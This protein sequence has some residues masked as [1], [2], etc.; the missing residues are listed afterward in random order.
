MRIFEKAEYKPFSGTDYDM[1]HNGILKKEMR[2]SE[3]EAEAT[4]EREHDH[5]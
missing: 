4:L 3:K 1:P 5:A 2:K